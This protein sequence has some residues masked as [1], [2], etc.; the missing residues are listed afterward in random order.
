MT[1]KVM[2]S[3]SQSMGRNIAATFTGPGGGAG[4]AAFS[5]EVFD[6]PFDGF[7]GLA[8]VAGFAGAWEFLGGF[9]FGFSIVQLQLVKFVF[10]KRILDRETLPF[11]QPKVIA[12]T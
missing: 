3:V 2:P 6:P 8:D 10:V 5:G 9:G 12:A 4:L 1:P 11:V 7:T